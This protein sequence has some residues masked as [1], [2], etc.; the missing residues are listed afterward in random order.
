MTTPIDPVDHVN[1]EDS[2]AG[3]MTDNYMQLNITQE[4]DFHNEG[5]VE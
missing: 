3:V 2:I 5:D 4:P 1:I